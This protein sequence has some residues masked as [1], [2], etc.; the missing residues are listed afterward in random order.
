MACPWTCIQLVTA[1]GLI[2]LHSLAFE[3]LVLIFK[4]S[5]FETPAELIHFL[6]H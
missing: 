2:T 6:E 3:A 4:V 1:F 5:A